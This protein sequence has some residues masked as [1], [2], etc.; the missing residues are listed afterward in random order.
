[1]E[2]LWH[3]DRLEQVLMIFAIQHSN[4][5]NKFKINVVLLGS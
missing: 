2:H 5:D 3:M 1:M 4:N